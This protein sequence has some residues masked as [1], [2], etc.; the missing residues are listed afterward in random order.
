MDSKT[1]DFD[2]RDNVT[3]KMNA[4]GEYA[5]DAKIYYNSLEDDIN[6]VINRL[7][8]IDFKIHE[9]FIFNEE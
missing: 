8:D 7:I 1:I 6:D 9:N 3:L 5:Y 4:K 2:K